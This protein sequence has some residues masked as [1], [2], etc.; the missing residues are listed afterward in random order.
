MAYSQAAAHQAST[1]PSTDFD[2]I[3][4]GAGVSGLYQL[5]KLRELGLKV[6]VFET[7]NG[8]GGTWYW[9]RYPGARFDSESWTYGYSFSQELLEEWDWE[10]HFAGQPETERYLNY[11]A[12]KFDLRRDIQF[13]SRVTAAQYQEDMRSWDVE[14]ENGR[15]HSARFLITAIGVLS[16]ATMPTIPG[17]E[18]FQGQSCHTHYWP[19]EP[20][21]FDGKRVAVIGTGAT[22]VQ[23]ITEVAKTVGH[24]TVFQRTPQWCAPLHNAK[25]GKEEM[26]RIRANYPEI[27]T[28]C[29]ETYG[30]FIHATDPRSTFEV[31]P[32]EREAFWEKLYSEPGFGIWMGNFRDVLVDREANTLISDF[33]A[34]KIRQR[35]K[36]PAMAEKLIPK[37]HGFGTR[38]VPLESGYYEVYNQ[39]NVELVD[40]KET[41]IER[42]TPTGIK[43]SGAEYEF[44]II[45]YATGF[46]AITGSFDRIDI[47]GVDGLRLKDKWKD[48]PQ[49]F[50]GI[51]VDGFPNM[52]MVMGP[53]AG[54]GNFPRAAEYSA[55]WVTGL[56]RF[57]R[58]RDLA[59]LEATAA[60]AAA[61]TDHVIA[62]SEGLLFTEV[63]S[64]M[65]GI[66]R[67][68]EG[69]QV[70]RIM[71]YSGGH[72]KF[73]ERC[74]A[75]VADGYRE[76]TLA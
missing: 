17:V 76:L 13:K 43:T 7:G 25:I 34:R 5:Y 42:I 49:T 60:G 72:P 55:D 22:G 41:P 9:N 66:N 23:T 28:R 36:D 53:H 15:R 50:L 75:V 71:R 10:E 69:K 6:R 27:F 59:R 3:I 58:D 31:T 8:V 62:S 68:V 33:L 45:I 46:D 35:V 52:L 1:D 29:Q 18:T 21:S 19:K 14:L 26:R 20:V 44:D 64:W 65:T 70:R 73:R 37:N 30:C 54:L 56:I 38:R 67:N 47:C 61:W 40:I 2:A 16:A 74:E 63:D 51:L 12:D 24:L 39:P 48:G 57:A 4:I 11:V 32:K